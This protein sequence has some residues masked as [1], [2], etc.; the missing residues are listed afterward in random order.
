MDFGALEGKELE[1]AELSLPP[2]HADSARQFTGLSRAKVFIGCA[3]W[4]RPEW[5]GSVYPAGTKEK[6]YLRH[7]VQNFNSIELNTTFYSIKKANV[8]KWAAEASGDF[9]FCP[10]FGQ[11]I[12]HIK[13][14]KDVQGITE[15]Y[16]DCCLAFGKHFGAAFLQMPDNFGPKRLDDLRNYLESLPEDFRLFVELRHKDWFAD[17]AAFDDTFTMLAD[18]GFGAVITDV[19]GRRDVLHMRLTVPRAFIRFNGY[20]L[21]PS[22]YA[23]MDEWVTRIRA[24]MKGGMEEIYFFGHQKD[25]AHTPATCAYM[26]RKLNELAGS[27]LTLPA[28]V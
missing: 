1:R 14:L 18:L 17:Q 25:E 5:V 15:Y 22:D 27:G 19:A 2:D 16:I 23:R 9:R 11:R 4:G 6:D 7:Y 8:E 21:I 13:R 28:G 10:K 26:I 3:K 20:G 24:W 12:S